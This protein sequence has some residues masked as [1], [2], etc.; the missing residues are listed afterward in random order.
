MQICILSD[1]QE[2]T[3]LANNLNSYWQRQIVVY[4]AIGHASL[5][6]AI[7]L[8]K[9]GIE[10]IVTT[11]INVPQLKEKL[12]ISVVA[13]PITT[14]DLISTLSEAKRKSD[15]VALFQFRHPNSR[16]PEISE[17][18]DMKIEQFLFCN[19][20]EATEK[21]IEAHEKGFSFFVGGALT[22]NIAHAQGFEAIPFRIRSDALIRALKYTQDL[23]LIRNRERKKVIELQS[24]VNFAFEG[25]MTTDSQG[26][27]T[28]VN[29]VAAK[30]LGMEQG[31]AVGKGLNS[32]IP[33]G[34]LNSEMVEIR[35]P[36]VVT[37]GGKKLVISCVPIKVN[38]NL[39]GMVL[40]LQDI[41]K[42]QTL[43][44]HIRRKIFAKGH[45]A[46]FTFNDIIGQSS[47]I[48][49]VISHARSFATTDK[50]ILIEGESGTGKEMFAQ[51]IHNA[52]PRCSQPFVA[53]NCASLSENLLESEL[54]G[55]VEG[56]FSG[57]KKGGKQGLFE[58]AHEGTIFLD[59]IGDITFSLQVKLL[60]VLQEKQ[61][62]RIGDDRIIPVDVRVIAATNM[63]LLNLAKGGKFRYDLYYRLNV[64]QLNIPPLRERLEDIPRIARHFLSTWLRN[65]VP[66]REAQFEEGIRVLQ[67]Y[68]WPGNIRELENILDRVQA[69]EGIYGN[70]VSF[71]DIISEVINF[72]GACEPDTNPGTLQQGKIPSIPILE[73]EIIRST[74]S[75]FKGSKIQLAEQLGISRT[76]LWRHLK[77]QK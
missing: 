58:I 44:G 55:Y 20:K 62:M 18:L 47:N 23:R 49:R 7:E 46:R 77:S 42:V 14:Y 6:K 12:S 74:S 48:K 1:H 34:I 27:I 16:I 25:I 15:K 31:K 11:G 43:E 52:S 28:M 72:T 38:S 68:S 32:L 61:I 8:E 45:V 56:A 35:E 65:V 39:Q 13:I 75:N 24:I 59:E 22:C 36:D 73:Q 63:E 17:I 29:P 71:K 10:D 69:L 50:T 33:N 54:F 21:M 66:E 40:H 64:L 70:R 30:L 9:Q 53:I 26:T 57:A 2:L 51:A 76:T 41:S 60:R 67:A 5:V 37:I 4:E 19:E 3:D